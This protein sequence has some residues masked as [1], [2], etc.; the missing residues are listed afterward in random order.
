MS[1]VVSVRTSLRRAV[2]LNLIF[3]AEPTRKPKP[4][5]SPCRMHLALPGRATHH[6]ALHTCTA[7]SQ[8]SSDLPDSDPARDSREDRAGSSEGGGGAPRCGVAAPAPP[9]NPL[10]SRLRPFPNSRRDCFCEDRETMAGVRAGLWGQAG[11]PSYQRTGEKK[12]QPPFLK[13]ETAANLDS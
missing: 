11:I 13:S 1:R 9:V 6:M 3:S 10:F 4:G 7:W 12:N 2:A 8:H 5:P